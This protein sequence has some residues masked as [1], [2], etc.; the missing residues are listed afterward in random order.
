MTYFVFEE[1]TPLVAEAGVSRRVKDGEE[2]GDVFTCLPL[3]SGE[4]L[5]ALSDGM[6]S[7][8]DAF[9]ESSLVIEL[10]EQMAEAG[11]SQTSRT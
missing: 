5:I 4:M 1:D 7:G 2:I 10:L 11:F 6:G 8:Q 3:P 9:S